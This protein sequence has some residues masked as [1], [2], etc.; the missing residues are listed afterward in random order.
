M[1]AG[2]AKP[3]YPIA[4]PRRLRPATRIGVGLMAVGLMAIFAIAAWLQPYTADGQPRNMA[5]HTQLGLP[6]CS[7]VQMTGKPC[8]ACG[9]TTSFSLLLHAD[10]LNS[11][12][13]NW[14]G[15]LLALFCLLLVPW[16]LHAAIRGRFAVVRDG[17]LLA[18]VAV[19]IFLTLTLARWAVVWFA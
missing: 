16:G 14:V 2:D 13:A 18:T 1:T 12:R 5:T 8:P 15:T 17:E 10:P 9:M 11:V 3:V 4:R 7:M 6:P 19:G